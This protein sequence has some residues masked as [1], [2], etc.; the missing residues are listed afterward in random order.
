[1]TALILL[2]CF[3]Y[4]IF[5]QANSTKDAF[6]RDPSSVPS[7]KYLETARGT[8]L[9]IS[10]W[11]GCARKI[12]YTGDWLM[13]L[14]WCLLCGPTHLVP[15]FYCIYFGI[16]LIHRAFRDDHMCAAKYGADWHRYKEAVPYMFL[17]WIL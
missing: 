10:G 15:Y 16:L 7:I 1:M 5:R 17:P 4:Y 6:R 13:A 2:N 9:M 14:S 8:K 3:G 12:N 11:W